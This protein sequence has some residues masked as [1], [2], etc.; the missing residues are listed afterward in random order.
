MGD[1]D[2][3]NLDIGDHVPCMKVPGD[4]L[5]E[6]II[7]VPGKKTKFL[8]LISEPTNYRA[9]FAENE[10]LFLEDIHPVL[11]NGVIDGFFKL[12]IMPV[13]SSPINKFR[14]KRVSDNVLVGTYPII[15][16]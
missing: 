2:Q 13:D 12:E 6:I 16:D 14:F 4:C 5:P 1:K 9:I 8:Q 7:Y 15:L 10:D 3:T 11:V